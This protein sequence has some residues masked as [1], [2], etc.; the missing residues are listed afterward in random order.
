MLHNNRR[1]TLDSCEKTKKHRT[2]EYLFEID[3]CLRTYIFTLRDPK[4]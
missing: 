3:K 1:N 2:T 4:R